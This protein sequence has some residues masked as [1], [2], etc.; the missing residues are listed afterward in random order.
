MSNA[1]KSLKSAQ[2]SILD[3][4]A[5]AEGMILDNEQLINSLELSK[6]QSTDIQKSL[7]ET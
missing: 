5:N 3:L 1:R 2:D 6:F 4:L 7:E